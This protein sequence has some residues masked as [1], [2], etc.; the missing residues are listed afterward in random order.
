MPDCDKIWNSDR[1]DHEKLRLVEIAEHRWAVKAIQYR[2]G[3]VVMRQ[4]SPNYLDNFNLSYPRMLVQYAL[5]D[6]YWATIT[7]ED[8]DAAFERYRSK[9]LKD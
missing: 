5:G 8:W 1:S 7:P 6:K 3:D 9:I 2:T 4:A